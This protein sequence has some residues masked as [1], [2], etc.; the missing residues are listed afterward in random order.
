MQDTLLDRPVSHPG[1]AQAL[2]CRHL[3]RCHERKPCMQKCQTLKNAERG[4]EA[5]LRRC[6]GYFRQPAVLGRRDSA[7]ACCGDHA[8]E[9]LNLSCGLS[10]CTQGWTIQQK[11]VTDIE[12]L[13]FVLQATRR[14][15]GGKTVLEPVAVI[16]RDCS[17]MWHVLKVQVIPYYIGLRDHGMEDTRMQLMLLEKPDCH[18]VSLSE[19]DH[20][21]PL[22]EALSTGPPLTGKALPEVRL[23]LCRSPLIGCASLVCNA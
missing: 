13:A 17:N 6:L 7:G 3:E 14:C 4:L 19:K 20:F 2:F 22:F 8:E 15:E 10:S 9:G 21:M 12:A 23:A 5:K 16:T 18:P 11:V 1:G